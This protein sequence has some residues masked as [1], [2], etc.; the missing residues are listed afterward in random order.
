MVHCVPTIVEFIPDTDWV[1]PTRTI[2]VNAF[3]CEKKRILFEIVYVKVG[4]C[5][6]I[7]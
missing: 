7:H 6:E 3:L 4:V 1:K 2:L 5:V